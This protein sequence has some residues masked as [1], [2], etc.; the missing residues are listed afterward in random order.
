MMFGFWSLKLRADEG[1]HGPLWVGWRVVL[2][3]SDRGVLPLGLP[4]T[5]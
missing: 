5:S 3:K 4:S 1:L 2:M